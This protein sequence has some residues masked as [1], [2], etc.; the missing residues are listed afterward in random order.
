MNNSED[1]K[2]EKTGSKAFK[3]SHLARSIKEFCTA[4]KDINFFNKNDHPSK[5]IPMDNWEDKDQEIGWN[6]FKEKL[7]YQDCLISIEDHEGNRAPGI[8]DCQQGFSN[9]FGVPIGFLIKWKKINLMTEF[10]HFYK[11]IIHIEE[12]DMNDAF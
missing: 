5:V 6:Y 8:W 12:N 7:P 11:N 3:N 10:N 9:I 4:F 1:K 2:D